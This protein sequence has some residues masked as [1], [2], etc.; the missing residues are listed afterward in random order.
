LSVA[1]RE[2]VRNF[3]VGSGVGVSTK[4]NVFVEAE[5]FDSRV[6]SHLHNERVGQPR[7]VR[8]MRIDQVGGRELEADGFR[9][10]LEERHRVR[11]GHT[12]IR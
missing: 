9:L 2:E 3:E 5:A 6:R 1:V 11:E 8:C 10:A 12:G 7:V 4:T